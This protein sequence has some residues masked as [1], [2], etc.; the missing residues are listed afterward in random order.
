MFKIIKAIVFLFIMGNLAACS[1]DTV[2]PVSSADATVVVGE[3]SGQYTY[4]ILTGSATIKVSSPSKGEVKIELTGVPTISGLQFNGTIGAANN[5][6]MPISVAPQKVS[7]YDITPK[8]GT[9]P[10]GT[11]NMT[12]KVLTLDISIANFGDVKFVGNKK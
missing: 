2:T 4:V 6:I 11:Y 5:N 12:T 1:S 3:Y 10:T 8:N 9:N 7:N